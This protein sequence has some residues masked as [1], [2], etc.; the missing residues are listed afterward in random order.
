MPHGSQITERGITDAADGR[1]FEAG[2]DPAIEAADGN[3]LDAEPFYGSDEERRTQTLGGAAAAQAA[4]AT[5]TTTA[6][7]DHTSTQTPQARQRDPL[8]N[9]ADDNPVYGGDT[10]PEPAATA[11]EPTNPYLVRDDPADDPATATDDT[12]T[13]D[14]SADAG[15]E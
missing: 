13:D 6:D 11:E 2:T 7:P 10:T 1:I 4:Q 8:D 12:P 9:P 15:G 5:A 3:I 14:A